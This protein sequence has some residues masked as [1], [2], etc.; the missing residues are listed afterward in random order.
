MNLKAKIFNRILT[1]GICNEKRSIAK[2]QA[3]WSTAKMSGYFFKSTSC[4]GKSKCGDCSKN[5]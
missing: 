4:P 5:D 2:Q 1:G 3:T